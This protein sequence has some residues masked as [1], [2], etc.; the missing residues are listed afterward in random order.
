MKKVFIGVDLGGTKVI[1]CVLRLNKK[2]KI[3]GKAKQSTNAWEGKQMV[4]DRIESTIR[5]AAADAEL[6]LRKVEAIG[7]GGCS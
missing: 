7:V 1:S 2:F 6:S 4:F 3:L 5:S